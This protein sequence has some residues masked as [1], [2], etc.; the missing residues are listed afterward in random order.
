M[1]EKI[2]LYGAGNYCQL[3]LKGKQ[4]LD[5]E[6]VAIIDSNSE[7]WNSTFEGKQVSN[8]ERIKDVNYE[9]IIITA[10]A[11]KSILEKLVIEYDISI[12]KIWYYDF[13]NNI[14]TQCKGSK[15]DSQFN[16]GKKEKDLLFNALAV[17]TIQEDMLFESF[18]AGEF[19][20]Y[21]EIV[22]LG[23]EEDFRVIYEFFKTTKIS[24]NIVMFDE[25]SQINLKQKYILAG[26][27]YKEDLNW[28]VNE[29]SV[30]LEQCI[31]IPLFDVKKTLYF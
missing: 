25:K 26:E 13:E 10:L 1:K 3:L 22:V 18:L 14:I 28:L 15:F 4:L 21:S 12:D 2:I 30:R 27:S 17:K 16:F 6:I 29:K 23:N 11:V 31:I 9:K 7:K 24:N 8:P 5:Y 20:G 19:D